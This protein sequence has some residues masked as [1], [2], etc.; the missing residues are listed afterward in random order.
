VKGCRCEVAVAV[1]GGEELS[2]ME[3]NAVAMGIRW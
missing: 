1:G 2:E 3:K